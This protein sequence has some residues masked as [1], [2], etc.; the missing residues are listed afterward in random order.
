MLIARDV[1][2]IEGLLGRGSF[3]L[4]FAGALSVKS[5]ARRHL[6]TPI[7][8]SLSFENFNRVKVAV[9]VLEAL[10]SSGQGVAMRNDA[11]EKEVNF[12]Q[13]NFEQATPNSNVNNTMGFCRLTSAH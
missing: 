10:G 7:Q 5:A 8:G 6:T 3:G 9:K 4:V 13:Y 2:K 11:R 1:L 12:S